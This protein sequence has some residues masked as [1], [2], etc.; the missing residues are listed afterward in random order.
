M[1]K[2]NVPTQSK[3]SLQND[4]TTKLFFLFVKKLRWLVFLIS[5]KLKLN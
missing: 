1:D 4:S 3:L 5:Q 2:M